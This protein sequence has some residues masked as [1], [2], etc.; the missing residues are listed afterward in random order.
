LHAKFAPKKSCIGKVTVLAETNESF[1]ISRKT[2]IGAVAGVL[3]VGI[4]PAGLIIPQVR[5]M[6]SSVVFLQTTLPVTLPESQESLETPVWQET[7]VSQP[8][9][10]VVQIQEVVSQLQEEELIAKLLTDDLDIAYEKHEDKEHWRVV[11]MRVTGYCPCSKCC[12]K[13]ADGITASNHKII[14]GDTFVAADKFHP[15]GTEMI[16][17]GYNL[18]QP[19]KVLDRGSAIKGNRLDVFFHSHSQ[20]QKWGV[21]NLDVL[22][23]VE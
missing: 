20:A 18:G 22:V 2:L 15:F 11:H 13:Y 4:L 7:F 12:G 6:G 5:D 9:E 21:K 1:R 23:K 17:P 3:V 16:I 14:S 8:Q 19:V 10:P